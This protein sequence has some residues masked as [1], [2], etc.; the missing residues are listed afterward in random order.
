MGK[1]WRIICKT[2]RLVLYI[3]IGINKLVIDQK[4]V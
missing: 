2:K 4:Y 1:M 3:I